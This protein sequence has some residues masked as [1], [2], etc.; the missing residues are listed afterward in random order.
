MSRAEARRKCCAI[1]TRKSSEEGLEQGFNSLEAQRDACEAYIRSQQHEGWVLARSCYDDGGFSGGN[2]ERPAL[3]RLLADIRAGRIDI[4]VVYKV[5]RLTRSLAD[6]AR[7]VEIFDAE[8]VSFVSVTQQF[9]T[10]SSMGRLTLN[11]L[12]SFAQFE[13]EVTGERIRD[14]IAAS[15]KKGLWMGGNVPL[16]YDANE[17]ALVI[18][19]AE[20]ETVRRIFALYRELGCVRRVK[21]EADRLGLRTK[22]STTANGIERGGTPLSRGH[23]YALLANPIYRGRIAHKGALYPGQHPALIED[24]TWTAVRARLAANAGNHKHRAGAVEPSLLAGLL[25]DARG[26]RL[27]PSH[28]VKKGRRYRYYVSTALITEAGTDRAQGWRLAARE[29][30][31][32]VVKILVD[33]LTSPAKL[34]GQFGAAAMPSDQL[35]KMLGRARRIAAALSSSPGGRAKLVRGLVEQIILDEKTIIIKLWRGPLLGGEIRSSTS[36]NASDRAIELTAAVAFKQ[37]GVETKLVLPG[38][39]QHSSRC[40][41]VLI[42]AIARGRAWFEELATGRARSL[43]ELAR[44]DGI[45]RRYIRRLVGLAFLSPQLVEAILQGRQPAA[46]TATRL[47]ELDLPLDWT[48]Q[49][50]LLA[51]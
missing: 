40:D 8:G 20:A 34:V 16:G 51:S 29:I 24:E 32:A 37:H 6:F 5:D 4:V 45:T 12:L 49:H 50:R 27:T 10:T 2:L 25:V 36:E 38:L 43:E 18:N 14:K 13:R 39:A 7:L 28:A 33:A 3:Q 21:E 30:E 46:L 42:K 19:P 35:R 47:S 48:E 31:E 17:R 22:R 9:N 41:P 15:K 1:Y 11:V 26:E 44:R 23:I